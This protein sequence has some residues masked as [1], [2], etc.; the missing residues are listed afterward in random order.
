MTKPL[1]AKGFVVSAAASNLSSACLG[2]AM[3]AAAIGGRR[4]AGGGTEVLAEIGGRPETGA[5]GD[6][7]DRQG[8]LLQQIA[9]V[10]HAL[11]LESFPLQAKRLTEAIALLGSGR[12]CENQ[13]QIAASRLLPS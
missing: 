9:G 11:A 13:S 6:R 4:Q 3:E 12:G 2:I 10:V 1:A 8:R 7:F 5:H